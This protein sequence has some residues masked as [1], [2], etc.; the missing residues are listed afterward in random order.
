MA[1]LALLLVVCAKLNWEHG[2]PQ[3]TEVVGLRKLRLVV[4]VGVRARARAVAERE[5]SE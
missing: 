4:G 1:D 2:V 5:G 3:L